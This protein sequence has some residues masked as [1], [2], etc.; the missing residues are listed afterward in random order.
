MNLNVGIVGHSRT[1]EA[2]LEQEG[3]PNAPVTGSAVPDDFSAIVSGDEVHDHDLTIMRDYL[4]KGG[5]VLCSAKVYAEIRQTT[6]NQE[7]IRFLVSESTSPFANAGLVDIQ[8]RG[9]ISWNA[10]QLKTDRNTFSAHKGVFGNGHI[11]A[12]PF[13]VAEMV[14]DGRTSTKS[15][16]S[17]ERRLPFEHVSTVS[18]GGLR[19]IVARALE[20]LHHHRGLPYVHLWYYPSDARTVFAFRI[21]TDHGRPGEID[22]LYRTVA[23]C[24]I[25]ASWFL[26]VKSQ[27]L[28]LSMF[29]TMVHQELGVHCF[30][31]RVLPDAAGNEANIRQALTVLRGADIKPEGYAA[32]YGTWS[33]AMGE[34]VKRCGFS[35]SSEFGY[36]Y[37]N[38]PSYPLVGNEC[39]PVLQVPIHPVSIGSLRRQGYSEDHMKRYFDFVTG[40]KL[41]CREPLIF[42]HHPRDG[43]PEVL[44]HLF[45]LAKQQRIAMTYFGEYATWWKRRLQMKPGIGMRGTTI[46]VSANKGPGSAWL[47]ISRPNGTEAFSPIQEELNLDALSWESRPLPFALPPDYTR[48]RKFNYRIPL[49][50][51]VDLVTRTIRIGLN[52]GGGNRRTRLQ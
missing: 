23:S 50:K 32:P 47:R 26:D 37:D 21:D 52:V 1:W 42:Y 36:D 27:Q 46:R 30:E 49:T 19:K 6:Y 44:K 41:A 38:L 20:L 15:F 29:S 25:P 31:H 18:R 17:P 35:Y 24:D 34:A 14:Q 9:R 22:E 48:S 43:H 51:S 3:V 33:D 40:Q 39:S 2:L 5:A 10:N 7:F 11:I 8:S 45:A 28:Y 12:L 4:F 13:D 16:Y